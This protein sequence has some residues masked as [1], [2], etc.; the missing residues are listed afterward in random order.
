MNPCTHSRASIGLDGAYCPNCKTLFSQFSSEYQQILLPQLKV[1]DRIKVGTWGWQHAVVKKLE[2][3]TV[4]FEGR[5]FQSKL[6]PADIQK[7][8]YKVEEKP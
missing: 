5:D 8:F 1:G 3:L 6:S 2:P 4:Q 7:G